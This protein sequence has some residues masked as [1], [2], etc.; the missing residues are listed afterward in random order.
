M[1]G[2]DAMVADRPEHRSPAT[3][4]RGLLA[5]WSEA[6]DFQ[7]AIISYREADERDYRVL[8]NHGYRPR[9]AEY[10]TRDFADEPGVFDIVR[11]AY[12]SPLCWED[13]CGFR[14]TVTAKSVL[15]PSGYHEGSTIALEI[16][17]RR[18]TSMLHVSFARDRVSELEREGLARLAEQSRLVVDDHRE[19]QLFL[20]S[21]R[22]LEVMRYVAHGRSNAEI[23]AVLSVSRRTVATHLEHIFAK[24][25]ISSRVV[26]AV[27]AVELGLI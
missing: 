6:L 16:E 14:S 20:L 12:G 2:I 23:S 15:R 21:P 3:I 18:I 25:G 26:L 7:A 27:R 24:T 8:A 17:Q 4:A 5:R 19:R 22:E 13:V 1:S 11:S 10:L 9:V